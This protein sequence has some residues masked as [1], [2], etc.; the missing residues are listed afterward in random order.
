MLLILFYHITKEKTLQGLFQICPGSP[1][2][3]LF[4]IV[5]EFI[6]LGHREAADL[7][8]LEKEREFQMGFQR[9]PLL[10]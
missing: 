2:F 5:Y 4:T 1:F 9:S 8:Q 10:T 6:V 7:A 3:L